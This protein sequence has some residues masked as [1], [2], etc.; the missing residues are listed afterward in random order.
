MKKNTSLL[1]EGVTDA[2][3]F[4]AGAVAGLLIGRQL[5]WDLTAEGYGN[6]VMGGILLVGI[7]GG[8]GLQIARY[9]RK[10]GAEANANA[11]E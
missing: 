7:G 8:L 5:G 2:V 9:W 10:R 4:L 6:S 1:M 3:G 11:G